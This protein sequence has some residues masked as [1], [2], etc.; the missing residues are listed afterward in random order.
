MVAV[1]YLF[2][3]FI[4]LFFYLQVP[5]CQSHFY[6]S[7][8]LLKTYAQDATERVPQDDS[9]DELMDEIE[10]E[11]DSDKIQTDRWACLDCP[12]YK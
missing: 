6:S 11:E 3:L 5:M 1:R 2:I 7:A 10:N 4:Y 9:D 8:E 12:I